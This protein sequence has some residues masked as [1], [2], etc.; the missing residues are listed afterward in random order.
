VP[1][2]ILKTTVDDD[3]VKATRWLFEIAQKY[4]YI[5][6]LGEEFC[7]RGSQWVFQGRYA[8]LR[9]LDYN[10]DE[11]FC[12]L[13]SDEFESCPG[14]RSK[15]ILAFSA[16]KK[17]W[18]TYPEEP[19]F[20]F[21]ND[22]SVHGD[23]T[24]GYLGRALKLKATDKL[25][26]DFLKDF[27]SLDQSKNTIILLRSD[28]GMKSQTTWADFSEQMEH[29]A[30]WTNLII[31]K[32]I[33]DKTLNMKNTLSSNED[34]LVTGHDFYKTLLSIIQADSSQ[35]S[36]EVFE[37]PEWAYNL[38]K[39]KVPADRMCK[40]ARIFPDHCSCTNEYTNYKAAGR[41]NPLAPKLGICNFAE[42]SEDFT[43]VKLGFCDHKHEL[44]K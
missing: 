36:T 42:D 9:M 21:L 23:N 10:L 4:G 33:L 39:E 13:G 14:G 19:K 11:L 41:I 3:V 35:G 32:T 27:L 7:T 37:A 40:D 44:L 31:P 43:G 12:A 22:I 30:P 18:L 34:K 5:T 8:E 20:A 24:G 6:W 1:K 38:L 26:A 15:S 28:H 16:L 17:L 25:V 29:K 2:N